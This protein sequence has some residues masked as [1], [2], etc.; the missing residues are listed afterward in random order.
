MGTGIFILITGLSV[1]SQGLWTT[2]LTVGIS[3]ILIGLGLLM[4]LLVKSIT[5]KILNS[6]K[7]Y[8]F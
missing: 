1:A 2:I 4:G 8:H 7:R 3:L 5:P 6:I